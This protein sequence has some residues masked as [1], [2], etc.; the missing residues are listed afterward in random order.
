M[1]PWMESARN[2]EKWLGR[3]I[4][5]NG[6]TWLTCREA[7]KLLNFSQR[8]IGN[9]IKK[10]RIKAEKDEDGRYFIEK[11]EFFR[12]YPHAMKA[13]KDGT[14]EKPM[15]NESKKFLEEKIKHLQ[16]MIDEKRRQNEFLAE[17]LATFT[18]EK[19][20]MLDAI[21]SHAR[22]LEYKETTGKTKAVE[23]E[24]HGKLFE[25]WPFKKG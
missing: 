16:E 22:L 24:G 23:N 13:E 14:D 3:M 10:G 5:T 6:K 12:V 21:N 17:Q 8:H 18:E 20:K 1:I 11:S 7:A 25:W 2:Y 15:E 19:F 9:L 4:M